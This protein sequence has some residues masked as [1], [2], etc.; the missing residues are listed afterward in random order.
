MMNDRSFVGAPIAFLHTFP[1][2][3]STRGFFHFAS[4][5]AAR[6]TRQA[7]AQEL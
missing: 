5:D 1:L 6:E 4:Q 2:P 3:T 7:I